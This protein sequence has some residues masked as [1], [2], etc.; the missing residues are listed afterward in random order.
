MTIINVEPVAWQDLTPEQHQRIRLISTST[1]EAM[2]MVTQY[3][4]DKNASALA[5]EQAKVRE[6][7]EIVEMVI[8][9]PFREETQNHQRLVELARSAIAKYGVNHG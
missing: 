4:R 5:A 3:L 2:G 8:N 6:L 7:V 9:N 1:S